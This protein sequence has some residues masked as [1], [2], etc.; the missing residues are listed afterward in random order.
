MQ[1]VGERVGYQLYALATLGAAADTCRPGVHPAKYLVSH[2][3]A[4][5]KKEVK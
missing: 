1:E 4:A 2:V 5:H 3:S